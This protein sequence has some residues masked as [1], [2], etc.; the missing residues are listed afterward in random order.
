MLSQYNEQMFI[1]EI[2]LTIILL[3]LFIVVKSIPLGCIF[4]KQ[5]FVKL[6]SGVVFP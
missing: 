5:R 3:C 4:W 1:N 2:N 6:E